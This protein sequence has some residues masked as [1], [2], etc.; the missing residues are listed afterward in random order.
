MRDT[1]VITGK[2]RLSYVSILE[3]K[4]MDADSKPKYSVSVIIPKSDKRTIQKI[5]KA[6]EAAALAGKDKFGGKIP[7]NL[8]TPLRD[9]DEE[10]DDEAYEDCMFL[11]ASSYR[12]PGVVDQNRDEIM[13][14]DQVYSGVYGRV[15]LNFYAYSVSGSKG[16]A[17][18]LN[19]VQVYD[20]GESLGGTRTSAADAFDDDEMEM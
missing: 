12:K 20:E 5:L 4:A 8:K 11:N 6:Q 18:G 16:I 10:K 3:P 13:D 2:V 7:K 9:G 1:S 14:D 17:A 19:N 15:D